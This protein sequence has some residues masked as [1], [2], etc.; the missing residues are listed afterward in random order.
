MNLRQFIRDNRDEIDRL[1]NSALYRH[2]GRGGKGTIPDPPPRRNDEERRQWIMNDEG[3][4]SWAR[5]EG[6]RA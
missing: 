1:I 3:L 2:D 4:Y 6:V 5:S